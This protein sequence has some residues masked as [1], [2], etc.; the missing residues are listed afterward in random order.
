MVSKTLNHAD[1]SITG[2]YDRYEYGPEKRRALD[3]WGVR[4]KE[5]ISGEAAPEN[6]VTF[7]GEIR[8]GS[9]P[10]GRLSTAIPNLFYAPPVWTPPLPG[11]PQ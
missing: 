7:Q 3:A 6:V 9:R 1:S 8:L 11:N 10:G 5:I 4:L 2:V